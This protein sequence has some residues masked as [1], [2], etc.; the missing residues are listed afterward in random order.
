MTWVPVTD[1]AFLHAAQAAELEAAA[2]RVLRGGRYLRG[3]ETEA[4]EHELAERCGTGGAVAVGSGLDA[5]RL[6]LLALG[7]G[8]GDEVLVPSH[9]AIATWLAV[10]HTGAAVVPVDVDERTMLLDP[11]AVRAA[12]GP[13]TAA[14]VAVHLYGLTV[15]V[16]ALRELS[17]R[18]G[19]ALVEDCAQALGATWAGRPAGSFGAAGA[20]S[21]YPTKNLGAAGDGGIVT[22]DD[23][24]LLERVRRLANYGERERNRS[25]VRGWNSRLDEVQAAM[26][27]VKLRG[28]EGFETA[29]RHRAA[30]YLRA[31]A[32]R[33]GIE[34]PVVDPRCEPVWHQF[35][36]RVP[37]RD[38]V[39]A[40]L[41]QRG[42]ETLVHYPQPP[43]RSA[44]YA[45]AEL[46]PL[47]VADRLAARVLSLPVGPHVDD[48]AG[49]LVSRA[50]SDAVESARAAPVS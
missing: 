12:V 48:E 13:R 34:L 33:P 3:P 22:S 2:L 38:E 17:S 9:T 8:A 39:R 23:A 21:L 29:R 11:A 45:D 26:L 44:A 31:L 35:V 42:V 43:H 36:V 28:L 24:G 50:L 6:A 41:A 19:L 37:R 7:I 25:E 10:A 4:F 5:L 16:S 18:H 32:G 20:F 27:R 30:A 46:G 49:E 40:T 47:P 15:D 14:V 1:L